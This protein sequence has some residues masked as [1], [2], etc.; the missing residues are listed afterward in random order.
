LFYADVAGVRDDFGVAIL[1]NRLAFGTGNVETTVIGS[2]PLNTGEWIHVAAVREQ[3]TGTI[4]IYVNGVLEGSLSR[5]TPAR[6]TI[7][8]P[9]T[10]AGTSSTA[11]TLP[12]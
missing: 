9:W 7:R 11:V 4:R 3:A 2:T 1:N 12:A 6:W 8:R 10:S 5:E